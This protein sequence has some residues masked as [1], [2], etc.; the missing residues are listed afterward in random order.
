M[1]AG[2]ERD[3]ISQ[4]LPSQRRWNR[5]GR[6]RGRGSGFVERYDGERGGDGEARYAQSMSIGICAQR[7]DNGRYEARSIV[8][9][10]DRGEWIIT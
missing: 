8:I 6:D 10:K 1:Q 4:R 2:G 5:A 9:H 3:R 7:R